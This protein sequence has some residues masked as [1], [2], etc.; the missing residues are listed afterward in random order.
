MKYYNTA[1]HYML[2]MKY[3]FVMVYGLSWYFWT[4]P[5]LHKT[6]TL[7]KKRVNEQVNCGPEFD[8]GTS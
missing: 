8:S 3:K 6:H 7:I 2:L 4:Q 5:F 1:E